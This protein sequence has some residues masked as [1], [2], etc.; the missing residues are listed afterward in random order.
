MKKFFSRKRVTI[1]LSIVG[2]W[3]AVTLAWSYIDKRWGTEITFAKEFMGMFGPIGPSKG[4]LEVYYDDEPL[5]RNITKEEFEE[6]LNM[7]KD[8]LVFLTSIFDEL[9][10]EMDSFLIPNGNLCHTQFIWNKVLCT[11]GKNILRDPT[12][13]ELEEKK[14]QGGLNSGNVILVSQSEAKPNCAYGTM[15]IELPIRF[16]KFS[17][18]AS[19]VG[20][21]RRDGDLWVKLKNCKKDYVE[22]EYKCK[23]EEFFPIFAAFDKSGR[24]LKSSRGFG[25]PRLEDSLSGKSRDESTWFRTR[26]YYG[27]IRKLEVYIPV[28]YA[29][30]SVDIKASAKPELKENDVWVVNGS[31][32]AADSGA[33]KF[34][35]MDVK[36]LKSQ[37]KIISIREDPSDDE[38]TPGIAVQLPKVDNSAYAEIDFGEPELFGS[39]GKTVEYELDVYG[40]NQKT[41]TKQVLFSHKEE[42]KLVKYK[43]AVGTVSIRYPSKLKFLLFSSDYPKNG[44]IEVQFQGPQVW[45]RGNKYL[46]DPS[47]PNRFSVFQ[48]FDMRGRRLR[49]IHSPGYRYDWEDNKAFWGKPKVLQVV[50]AEEWIE[51]EI[52]YK[53]KPAKM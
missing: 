21:I 12:A 10:P 32:Y 26:N 20:K 9:R 19:D 46:N 48:A 49:E 24:R 22:F 7:E 27:K 33:L 31:R 52:P 38:F 51:L 34:V 42:E 28:A 16:A 40:L 41:L 15:K 5:P 1:I 4:E 18:D 2:I 14:E 53:L 25:G 36:T 39:W 11:D 47:F 35:S 13:E 17:F 50:H 43:K 44:D 30:S 37:T 29:N 8:N 3:G 45:I 23:W 6:I